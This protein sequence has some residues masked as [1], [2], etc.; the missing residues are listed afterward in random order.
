VA[1]AAARVRSDI[2]FAVDTDARAFALTLDDGPDPAVTP[3][4]LDVLRRHGARATFFLIG[5][6]AAR[7]PELVHRIVGEGHEIG[8]HMWLDE[9]AA[10]LSDDAFTRSLVRTHD[11]LSG[12]GPLHLMRP[13]SGFVGRGK[14]R[15]A[16]KHGYR[17]VLGSVYPFDPQLR[18]SRWMSW[19]VRTFV[20]PGAFVIL[21][22]RDRVVAVLEEVL[23]NA[24]GRG[25]DVVTA[26]A[27]MA[28]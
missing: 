15:I 20:H 9:P 10:R 11:V 8:N 6:R 18:S 23:S 24:A 7:Q 25:F 21:H 26:S 14:V 13:G 2:T 5:S 22:E 17:T 27:L 19:C 4:V 12:F 28:G 1:A 3:R 16:A